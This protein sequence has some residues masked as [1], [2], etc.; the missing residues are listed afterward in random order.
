MGVLEFAGYDDAEEGYVELSY[1]DY[2]SGEPGTI[3]LPVDE[4]V[5]TRLPEQH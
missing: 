2:E 4:R 3:S 1:R 5:D